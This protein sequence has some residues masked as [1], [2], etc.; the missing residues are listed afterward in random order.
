[1]AQLNNVES[2]Y[3]EIILLSNTDRDNLFS[4][5]KRDFYRNTEIVAHTTDGKTLT[6][7]LYQKK[8]PTL[9]L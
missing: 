8:A 6:H 1:M 3:N 2:I 7:E 5:M 9:F 4:R